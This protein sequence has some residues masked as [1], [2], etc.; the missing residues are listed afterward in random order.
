MFQ[1]LW[2]RTVAV[3][4]SHLS[5]IFKLNHC[6][7]DVFSNSKWTPH[8]SNN[9]GFT[10]FCKDISFYDRNALNTIY[11]RIE[12]SIMLEAWRIS[13]FGQEKMTVM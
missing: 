11:L 13:A 5:R 8:F 1:G 10:I 7:Y 2:G 6:L 9:N 4:V 3:H 12:I